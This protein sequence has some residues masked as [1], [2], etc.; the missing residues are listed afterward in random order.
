M[1]SENNEFEAGRTGAAAGLGDDISRASGN[2]SDAAAGAASEAETTASDL[3]RKAARAAE[4][5]RTSTAAGLES[6]ASSVHAGGERVASAVHRVG[7]ALTS[8]A[9]YV[10]RNEI[11]D[12]MDD[13]VDVVRDHPGVS[14]MCATAL[15]FLLGRAVYRD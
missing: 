10:R 4:Q 11:A 12:M 3:K 9:D 5:V 13:L 14:L 15:G 6:A 7:D 2:W 8:G 1:A